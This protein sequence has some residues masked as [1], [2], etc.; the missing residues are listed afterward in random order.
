MLCTNMSGSEKMKPIIIG[1]SK[2]PRCLRQFKMLDSITYTNSK[3]AWMTSSIY[4]NWLT[5]RNKDLIGQK[6]KIL[7]ILD[8]CSESL[9]NIEIKFLPKNYTGNLQPL[10]LGIIR[11][12]KCKFEKLKLEKILELVEKGND[13]Y[14]CYKKINLVDVI[15]F[16]DIAWNEVAES[17]IKNCFKLFRSE[18]KEPE[19]FIAED[20]SDEKFFQNFSDSTKIFDK[21]SST[22]YLNI[23]YTENDEILGDFLFAEKSFPKISNDS[24]ESSNSIDKQKNT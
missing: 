16:T 19:D 11:S 6:C 21:I 4:T 17:T 12:F 14:Q 13:V 8:N 7:L 3:R 20:D 9:S 23:T 5:N 2:R 24:D 15:T 18:E 10:D 22:D 1:K